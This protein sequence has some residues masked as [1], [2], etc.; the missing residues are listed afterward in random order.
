[1]LAE[2]RLIEPKRGDAIQRAHPC[3]DRAVAD[4]HSRFSIN[5]RFESSSAR[6][7]GH[8]PS[9]R[10]RFQR[11]DSEVFLARQ[12]HCRRAP[13]FV[14]HSRD[15]DVVPYSHGRKLFER[16]GE[17]KAFLEMRGGHNDGFIF[18]RTEWVAQLAAFFD[19]HAMK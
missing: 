2:A 7:R 12:Q 16:A 17:P 18:T 6:E 11:H 14:A 5:H 9:A 15:D 4:E 19:Q 13:I 1:M 3:V 8:R 10:L